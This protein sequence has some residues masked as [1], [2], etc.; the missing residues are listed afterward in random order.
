MVKV[1]RVVLNSIAFFLLIIVGAIFLEK[2]PILSALLF[3]SS[4]DQVE[5]VYTYISGKRLFPKYLF[6]LD[7][8]FEGVAVMAGAIMFLFGI[9]YY[10]YFHTYFFLTLMFLGAMIIS[11]ATEDITSYFQFYGVQS[12]EVRKKER[13]VRRKQ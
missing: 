11:S 10:P 9:M 5:D 4:I 12:I 6:P 13:F 7:M 3:L 8:L 2:S 1:V